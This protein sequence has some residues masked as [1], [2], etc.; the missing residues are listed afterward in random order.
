M[1]ATLVL[2]GHSVLLLNGGHCCDNW[3]GRGSTRVQTTTNIFI[4]SAADSGLGIFG[5]NSDGYRT[6]SNVIL[7][8]SNNKE[9]VVS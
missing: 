1:A 3:I 2:A 6:D 9:V 4:L 7:V 8:V 5:C